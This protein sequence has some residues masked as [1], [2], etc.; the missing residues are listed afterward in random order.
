MFIDNM[1][2]KY[3][4]NGNHFPTTVF[5]CNYKVTVWGLEWMELLDK[6]IVICPKLNYMGKEYPTTGLNVLELQGLHNSTTLLVIV[7]IIPKSNE[8][9]KYGLI[10]DY[11]TMSLKM[12]KTM[13]VRGML[14][15][16]NDSQY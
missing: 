3:Q 9:I 12:C 8:S 11:E 6:I 7:E 1:V 4:Y 14:N 15:S 5:Q 2:Y 13:M 10:L 16:R